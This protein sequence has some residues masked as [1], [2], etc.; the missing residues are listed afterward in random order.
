MSLVELS[1]DPGIWP[2]GLDADPYLGPL[3]H[4]AATDLSV[5][6]ADGSRRRY[7]N[8]DVAASAPCLS[9]VEAVVHDAQRW[10]S[11]V[12]RGAGFASAVSTEA[13]AESRRIIARFVGARPDDAVVITRN[14]TDALNLLAAV[15]PRDTTVV[16]YASEH[17]ANLLAWRD[18]DPLVLP[19]PGSADDA[20]EAL[21]RALASLRSVS[22]ARPLLAAVTGASNV[23][24]EVWPIRR[25]A[26]VAHRH[27]ARI[28]VDA[29]Q[30]APHRRVELAS[31]ELDY[32][33][34]SGHKLYA[35]FGAGALI[36][37]ADWL[38][39]GEPYLAGGGAVRLVTEDRVDWTTGPARHEAGT[40]NVLG[41][42]AFAAACLDLE[43]LG[44]AEVRRHESG[45]S[46]RLRRGLRRIPGVTTYVS[47]ED[48][49]AAQDAAGATSTVERI[50]VVLCNLDGWHH[51]LLAAVLSAEHGIGVRDGAFCAHRLVAALVGDRGDAVR[52]TTDEHP[53]AVRISVGVT[54]SIDDVDRLL[55]A[56]RTIGERGAAFDYELRDGRHVLVDDGRVAPDLFASVRSPTHW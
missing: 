25:L 9:S 3:A 33:A 11:S 15:L 31:N 40:P 22:P 16:T 51:G 24:G 44:A 54:T 53:G 42:I 26:A 35:P 48:P 17:H 2:V 28:V 52:V 20:V 38:D 55:G 45:L 4:C 21:D 7:V 18:L 12:H 37:R 36:G 30:L 5:P 56:L 43:R 47:W 39:A 6:L 1:V 41:A 46:D 8:L 50:G 19:V 23:P 10:Y 34:I 27:G 29:A 14:T 13:L 32:V 49:S